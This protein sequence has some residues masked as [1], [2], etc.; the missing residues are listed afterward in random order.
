MAERAKV[1]FDGGCPVCTREINYYRNRA[2][3]NN[4]EWVD[5]TIA[6]ENKLGV[7]LTRADALAKLHVQ[8]ADG[9]YAIGAAAF[10]EIWQGLPKFRWLGKLL[11][12]SPI[13]FF[14]DIG[15]ALFLRIRKLWR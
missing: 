11:T 7:G 10:A 3:A 13:G 2:G 15:Y 4:F 5:V 14:A 9:T 12:I 1:F 8:R 6:D